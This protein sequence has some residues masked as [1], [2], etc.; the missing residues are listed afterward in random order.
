MTEQQHHDALQA[1]NRRIAAYK[2]EWQ[3][4]IGKGEALPAITGDASLEWR[5]R[6]IQHNLTT[7]RD[8][9]AYLQEPR[10]D[11]VAYCLLTQLV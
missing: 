3:A 6:I 11:L 5:L 4:L 7:L 9:L 2:A 1:I 10:Y 8:C